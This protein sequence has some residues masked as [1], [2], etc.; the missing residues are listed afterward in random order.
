MVLVA[1]EGLITK[2]VEK[3]QDYYSSEDNEDRALYMRIGHP[4]LFGGYITLRQMWLFKDDPESYATELVTKLSN[5]A[6]SE[7]HAYLSDQLVLSVQILSP[8]HSKY[9]S[10]KPPQASGQP[11]LVGSCGDEYAS[12][13][14]RK[15]YLLLTPAGGPSQPKQFHNMCLIVSVIISHL[16]ALQNEHKV[17][18]E[19]VQFLCRH[20][21]GK[22]SKGDRRERMKAAESY[23]ASKVH[24][25]LKAHPDVSK[26]GPHQME[27]LLPLLSSYFQCQIWVFSHAKSKSPLE[28][29][30][31]P[32]MDECLIQLYLLCFPSPKSKTH[33]HCVPL[34][35]VESFLASVP[36]DI[37]FYCLE[38][39]NVRPNRLPHR[40][41]TRELCPSCCCPVVAQDRAN[42][43]KI[44]QFCVHKR[45]AIATHCPTCLVLQIGGEQCAEKHKRMCSQNHS[46]RCNHCGNKITGRSK[47]E[48]QEA[49]RLHDCMSKMCTACHRR[50]HINDLHLCEMS[51][52]NITHFPYFHTLTALQIDHYPEDMQ[53]PIFV[54]AEQHEMG[55]F[56]SIVFGDSGFGSVRGSPLRP[57]HYFRRKYI[58]QGTKI[59]LKEPGARRAFG[60]PVRPSDGHYSQ[61]AKCIYGSLGD[62]S[63]AQS[64]VEK[65]LKYI[66]HESFYGSIIVTHLCCMPQLLETL[67]AGGFDYA[68]TNR[69]THLVSIKIK[70]RQI[71]FVSFEMF[72]LDFN[73][74]DL[75]SYARPERPISYA[76]LKFSSADLTSKL[77]EWSLSSFVSEFFSPEV[78][79][80]IAAFWQ[81]LMESDKNS[82]LGDFLRLHVINH[83]MTYCLAG[84]EFVKCMLDLQKS[85]VDSLREDEKAFNGIFLLPFMCN[86]LAGYALNLYKYM[87]VQRNTIFHLP[88]QLRQPKLGETSR[89]SVLEHRVVHYYLHKLKQYGAKPESFYSAYTH[90][91]GQATVHLEGGI[92]F[93]PDMVSV[94]FANYSDGEFKWLIEVN[95]CYFHH[96]DECL[97]IP[98]RKRHE[99][100]KKRKKTFGE[101][102]DIQDRKIELFRRAYG[103]VAII[104]VWECQ[105]ESKCKGMPQ[106]TPEDDLESAEIRNFF[107]YHYLPRYKSETRKLIARNAIAQPPVTLFDFQYFTPTTSTST[108]SQQQQPPTQTV[109]PSDMK[110][111]DMTACFP[112]AA[113]KNLFPKGRGQFIFQFQLEHVEWQPESQ[114]FVAHYEGRKIPLKGIFLVRVQAPPNLNF[115]FLHMKV[116]K[117][118]TADT[119]RGLCGG[120][121]NRAFKYKRNNNSAQPT[122]TDCKHGSAAR[123]FVGE[124]V[125]TDLE[126][127]HKL[128][129][130]ITFIEG[131]CFNEFDTVFRSFYT[132]VCLKMAHYAKM[133]AECSTDIVKKDNLEE[134][135]KTYFNV[136]NIGCDSFFEP[137]PWN[138]LLLKTLAVQ[139]TGRLAP[140][141]NNT[142][143][144]Y[145][146]CKTEREFTNILQEPK[147]SL[148][149][150]VKISETFLHCVSKDNLYYVKPNNSGS[151]VHSAYI[152]SYAR[153]SLHEKLM[154]LVREGAKIF[155]QNCDSFLFT[156]P[157]SETHLTQQHLSLIPGNFKNVYPNERIVAFSALSQGTTFLSTDLPRHV[158]KARGITLKSKMQM[159]CVNV[160]NMHE[161]IGQLL[162]EDSKTLH[163]YYKSDHVPRQKRPPAATP[164]ASSPPAPPPPTASP[165]KRSAVTAQLLS[166][167]IQHKRRKCMSET[168]YVIRNVRMRLGLSLARQVITGKGKRPFTRPWG[169]R[170]RLPLT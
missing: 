51:P 70:S 150:I 105:F 146:I 127:A 119:A 82:T 97:N 14:R 20:G 118:D 25:F 164:S 69:H 28:T 40:C 91:N 142:S 160:P 57:T 102:Q 107:Q 11:L 63:Y 35:N 23:I 80:S 75:H 152:L 140:N 113:L 34:I 42:V 144:T 73:Y 71:T 47:L 137:N 68:T 62:V 149:S 87:Y 148:N 61:D 93:K 99:V 111:I 134:E 59:E 151:V 81:A 41:R 84:C 141:S 114:S 33:A 128:G 101:L 133:P 3:L 44:K 145:H 112:H 15:Q 52:P 129:Y 155:M 139:F 65:V 125:N 98:H 159:D 5:F 37:C 10:K 36:R 135:L 7:R 1:L 121:L 108:S 132:Q 161:R 110:C 58:P 106:P 74:H 117:L 54:L 24:D 88:L 170:N 153:I 169:Y 168:Q 143:E 85:M 6:Q 126:Y 131:F 60:R 92:I 21:P 163:Q 53:F 55:A 18:W 86:T 2:I 138:R 116:G 9:L 79:S 49:K 123:A 31:P 147:S 4:L 39:R 30:H 48:L 130:Q 22:G 46:E 89:T 27:Q 109:P 90:I 76:P 50:H 156:I 26:R 165:R 167:N 45:G 17:L 103:H 29:V 157:R 124:Y 32:R 158:I 66:C 166:D 83:N 19:N 78:E 154:Q 72:S 100:C 38:S 12:A 94:N 67:A 136:Q 162:Q 104:I 13:I 122:Q 64:A 96:H 77:S 56:R 95:G 43:V 8:T 120:C 16:H 115:P